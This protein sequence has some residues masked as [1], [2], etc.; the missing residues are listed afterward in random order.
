MKFWLYR[1]MSVLLMMLM[2][3]TLGMAD[4]AVGQLLSLGRVNDAISSLSNRSD[5]ESLNQLSRAYYAIERWDEAI[6]AGERAVALQPQEASYHLWLARAYGRKAAQS[7]P[8]SAAS[9]ARKAKSEFER[10]VVLDTMDVRARADLSRYYTEAPAIMGGGLDKAR[11]QAIQVE[12]YDRAMSHL[13]LA[14]VAGKEKHFD[15]AEAQLQQAISS[16]ANP[17]DYWLQLADF[18]RV[19]GRLQEMEG[20]V[21]TAAAQNNKPAEVYFDAATQ[22]FLGGRNLSD[23]AQYLQKYLASGE[24]VESA[25]AFRA[26]Y[27]LGQIYEK[28]GRSKDAALEYRA[29]L[30]MASGFDPASRALAKLR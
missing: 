30:S 27:L 9:L 24:L 15:E 13:I 4:P 5:A 14:Q 20:A 23:A 16:A 8:L 3:P 28:M 21:S 17:A 29:S 7:N 12:K 1:F 11:E 26:H 25:P 6:K 18:Y 10:A 2:V 19:H 22:L